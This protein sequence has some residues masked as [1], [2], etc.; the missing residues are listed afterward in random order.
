MREMTE[1][2]VLNKL[3]TICAR[4]EHCQQEMLDKM[5]RW[6]IPLETQASVMAYLVAEGYVDEERYARAFISDKMTF[7]KW[8]IRKII[9]A[10]RMKGIR[11]EVYEA[12]IDELTTDNYLDNLKEIISQ[13]R[14]TT[15]GKNDYDIRCKLIRFGLSRGF[16]MDDI[17]KV[18]EEE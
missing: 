6:N 7:N 12:A 17:I 2:Q 11:P 13:K 15:T 9:Q 10:L 5:R 1:Q 18:L 4:G 3:T 16:E 8:G 14:K